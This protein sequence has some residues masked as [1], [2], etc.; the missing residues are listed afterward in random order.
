MK[1]QNQN[2]FG[3][4]LATGFSASHTLWGAV[5]TG[6]LF[7]QAAK[8]TAAGGLMALPLALYGKAGNILERLQLCSPFSSSCLFFSFFCFQG[9][10]LT[11]WEIPFPLPIQSTP[12][13]TVNW[14]LWKT[15]MRSH[16][17]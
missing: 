9:L 8:G 16:L 2:S 11:V 10:F 6:K 3:E 4:D 13:S 15:A 12:F 7:S 1:D 14:Q 17:R 5:K